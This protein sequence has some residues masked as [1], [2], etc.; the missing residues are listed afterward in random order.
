MDER[1]REICDHLRRLSSSDAATWLMEK[2]PTNT[3][4]WGEALIAMPHRSWERPDQI[5]LA[6]YYLAKIPYASERGYEAFASFMSIAR[7]ISVLR[8]Y[9]PPAAEDKRLLAYHLGPTLR[10]KAMSDTDKALIRSFLDDLG[11]S[12]GGI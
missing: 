6:N 5:R 12:S 3:N 4:N 1:Q 9:I 7:M 11:G 8:S 10:R 2:F